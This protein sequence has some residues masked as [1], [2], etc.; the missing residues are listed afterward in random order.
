MYISV[1]VTT[2]QIKIDTLF[3]LQNQSTSNTAKVVHR[4]TI[5]KNSINYA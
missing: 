1:N 3:C 4:G 2:T 5:Y